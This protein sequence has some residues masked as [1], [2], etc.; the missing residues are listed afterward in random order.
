MKNE[1]AARWPLGWWWLSWQLCWRFS[2][3]PAPLPRLWDR[4]MTLDRSRRSRQTFSMW[5]MTPSPA[6]VTLSPTDRRPRNC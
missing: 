1:P 3:S 4:N 6:R 2:T 5:Q